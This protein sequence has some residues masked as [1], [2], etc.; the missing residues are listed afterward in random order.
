MSFCRWFAGKVFSET[1]E[2]GKFVP[3]SHY[4]IG[5]KQANPSMKRTGALP[6]PIP[7]REV[8][9]V[10]V[11]HGVLLAPP[12]PLISIVRVRHEVVPVA[13]VTAISLA[14]RRYGRTRP[15]VLP[16]VSYRSVCRQENRPFGGTDGVRSLRDKVSRVREDGNRIVRGG[17]DCQHQ[18]VRGE[19]GV[20]WLT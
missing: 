17:C 2:R 19:G 5:R 7:R 13:V 15:G 18:A 12:L 11:S 20:V 3:M 14:S 6:L 16:P 1:L 4:L 9:I 8:A 10:L